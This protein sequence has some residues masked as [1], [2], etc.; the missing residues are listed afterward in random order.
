MNIIN[1]INATQLKM[2]LKGI[3]I[4]ELAGLAPAPFCG[5]LL[6]D[7]GASVIRIDKIGAPHL[8]SLGNGKRSIALNLKTKKGIDIFKRLCKSCD[9]I[10]DPYRKGVMEKLN[11]GP[12][13]LMSQNKKLIYARL[14]GFGQDGPYAE[15]AGHDINYVGLSG[16]LSIFG[17]Q[18]EKPTPPVNLAADFGG[19]GLMCAFGIVMALHER[20][21]SKKGQIID[22]S[23]VEGTAYLGSWF[24]RSISIPGLWGQPRGKN[25]LDT[26]THFYDTY[27][28]KD[29]LF[30]AVGALEPQFYAELLSKLDL[31]EDE[32]PQ[33]DDYEENRRKLTNIFKSKTQAQWCEIFDGTD[34]CV[35]PVLTFE[36]VA[37]HVHN[38]SQNSFSMGKDNIIV[39]N[40]SPRLSRTP[41]ES[42]ATKNGNIRP[43]DHTLNVLRE[44]KYSPS[45]IE[46]FIKNGIVEQSEPASKL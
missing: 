40:P 27:E 3:K 33:Y 15:M 1:R 29:G 42:C 22:T 35:T 26:G 37:S 20:N 12:A 44:Y 31:T 43:G 19:G 39:P 36:N 18:H 8:D 30:M 16:L 6:A 24:Y 10:I 38:V 4:L 41:G 14:T 2:A 21:Q 17:R 32:L 46:D 45:E 28:T 11:L 5:M 25:V 13:D 7:F 23:M 34:A 9:V